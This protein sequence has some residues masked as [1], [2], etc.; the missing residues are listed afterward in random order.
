MAVLQQRQLV[1]RMKFLLNKRVQTVFQKVE[2]HWSNKSFCFMHAVDSDIRE[3]STAEARPY[4][5]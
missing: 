3:M 1:V 5:R 4:V 2:K